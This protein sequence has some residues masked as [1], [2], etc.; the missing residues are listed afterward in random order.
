MSSDDDQASTPAAGPDWDSSPPV[1]S[2]SPRPFR[3]PGAHQRRFGSAGNVQSWQPSRRDRAFLSLN[4]NDG[5][6][7]KLLRDQGR[8]LGSLGLTLHRDRRQSSSAGQPQFPSSSGSGSRRPAPLTMRPSSQTAAHGPAPRHSSPPRP[9]D[10]AKAPG[11]VSSMR[12]GAVHRHQLAAAALGSGRPSETGRGAAPTTS[13]PSPA[14]SSGCDLGV[15]PPSGTTIQ[16]TGLLGRRACSIPSHEQLTASPS[17]PQ[18][19]PPP[20]RPWCG[21]IITNQDRCHCL[22]R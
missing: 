10:S 14:H 19:P 3:R 2:P 9:C 13:D 20:V 12:E 7:S 18:P 17:R 4:V 11:G 22:V 6:R 16:G 8:S 1:E 15:S 21:P 5:S